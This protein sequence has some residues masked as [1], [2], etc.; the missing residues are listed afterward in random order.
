MASTSVEFFSILIF[1]AMDR[2]VRTDPVI[3]WTQDTRNIA[4]IVT[5]LACRGIPLV[6]NTTIYPGRRWRWMGKHGQVLEDAIP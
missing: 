1:P 4:R 5:E 3:R 2:G 6:P